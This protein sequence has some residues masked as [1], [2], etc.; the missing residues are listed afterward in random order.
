[1]NGF[2]TAFISIVRHKQD[3]GLWVDRL[4]NPVTTVTPQQSIDMR[5]NLRKR[6]LELARHPSIQ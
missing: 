5:C 4:G 2:Q 6:V 3:K 1:M